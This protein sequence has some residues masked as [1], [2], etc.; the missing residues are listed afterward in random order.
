[1]PVAAV[2]SVISTAVSGPFGLEKQ[3]DHRRVHMNSVGDDVGGK[4]RI[5]QHLAENSGIA[6]AQRPHGIKSVS[7][8]AGTRSH[9][10]ASSVNVGVGVAQAHTDSTLCRFINDLDSARQFGRDGQHANVPARRLP[11][12]LKCPQGG[13]QQI[14]RRMH[15]PPAMADERTLQMNS[16]GPRP[17]LTLLELPSAGEPLRRFFSL[18]QPRPPASPVRKESH[19]AGR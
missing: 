5:G 14:F 4:P 12:A 9:S 8:V 3:L 13:W 15:S 16:Q 18:P 19:P 1:M 6:M 2:A 17:K 11:E 10:G 7:G